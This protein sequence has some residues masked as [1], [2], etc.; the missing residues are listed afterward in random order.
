MSA[1]E[2]LKALEAEYRQQVLP[3]ALATVL[4]RVVAVVKAAEAMLA[5]R[6]KRA[7]LLYDE[8]HAVEDA[9]SALEEALT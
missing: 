7:R 6:Q 5:A 8:E 1:S 2:K 4:P 9:L 3:D